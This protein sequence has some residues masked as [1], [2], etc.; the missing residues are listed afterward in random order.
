[1]TV[2]GPARRK[3]LFCL[4]L[5]AAIAVLWG[6]DTARRSDFGLGAFKAVFYGARCLLHH[7]DP[8]NPSILQKV[9]QEEC[10]R[11]PQKPT[12]AILFRRANL[13]CV[14]LP[15]AL[16]LVAPFA[17]LHWRLA[18]LLWFALSSAGFLLAAALIWRVASR[19]ALKPATLLLCLVL[20]NSS[21]LLGVGNLACLTVSLCIIAVWCFMEERFVLVGILCL[22]IALL[23]KPHDAGLVW[24]YFL[25]AGGVQRRRACLALGVAVTL[26][27]PA[28]VWNFRVAPQ[29]PGELRANLAALAARGSVN[30]PGPDS[31]TFHSPDY[32][33]CLQAPLSL[34]YDD[35]R[36]YNPVSYAICG[37]LLLVGAARAIR[38]RWTGRTVW[39]AL[40]AIASL[41]LLPVYHRTYDAKLLLLAI[42]A[43]A[44]LWREGGVRK[45]L[46]GVLTTL[47]ILSTS[48]VPA[49]AL[50]SA[51]EAVQSG[52]GDAQEKLLT[53]VVFRPAALTLLAMGIFYLALYIRA[54]AEEESGAAETRG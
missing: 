22:G 45:W 31:L 30:D 29:W 34:L 27:L 20:A 35:A 32:V 51:M 21:I 52:L 3:A 7:S 14:N 8:Y 5:S 49:T 40:A 28:L 6:S 50:L 26:A 25:L 19:Y 18:A 54:T 48:D 24:L 15:T 4:L 23:L 38:A 13:I 12:E 2:C 17:M 11:Y 43:C 10:D 53:V 36:F 39:L 33:V 16:F 44:M 46:A 37:V 9:Y 47:A 42:P 41:S 1:M